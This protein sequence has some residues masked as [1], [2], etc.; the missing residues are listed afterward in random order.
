MQDVEFLLKISDFG[1]SAVENDKD[2][3]VRGSCR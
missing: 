1:V 3:I 2:K